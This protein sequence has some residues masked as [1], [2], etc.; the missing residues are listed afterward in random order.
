MGLHKGGNF[1]TRMLDGGYMLVEDLQPFIRD[2][3][4]AMEDGVLTIHCYGKC[5]YQ[6]TPEPAMDDED[7][8][9]PVWYEIFFEYDE[10]AIKEALISA[11]Y[12]VFYAEPR[13]MSVGIRY[14][15]VGFA[16]PIVG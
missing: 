6:G 3:F 2:Y 11:G 5:V 15:E 14:A 4:V 16:F 8:T 13:D 9:I 12:E 10:Q 1:T 7:S